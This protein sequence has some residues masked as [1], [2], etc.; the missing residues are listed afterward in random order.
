MILRKLKD[1]ISEFG[2]L[3]YLLYLI[4][5]LLHFLSKVFSIEF[6]YIF[7]LP[8]NNSKRINIPSFIQKAYIVDV[9]DQYDDILKVFPVSRQTL[10]YR[11]NQNAVCL[12][13][14]KDKQPIGFLWL[15]Q[16]KYQEDIIFCDINM[17]PELAWDFEVRILEQFRLTPAFSVLWDHAFNYLEKKNV[18]WI[19]S[20]IS[21]INKPSVGVHEKLGGHVVGKI[22]FIKFGA[23]H[24][25]LDMIQRKLSIHSLK[26]RKRIELDTFIQPNTNNI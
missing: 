24:I 11:F 18:K 8:V 5:R 23:R 25:C 12:L 19:Y 15:I 4:N 1:G 3:I 6:F 21:T 26:N 20:R 17:N 16:K 7:V 2:I 9:L 13:I 22:M 14:K 10:E